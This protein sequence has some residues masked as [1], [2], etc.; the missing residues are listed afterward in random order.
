MHPRESFAET[1]PESPV[2]P[3]VGVQISLPVCLA[4]GMVLVD[5]A[6]SGSNTPTG[7]GLRVW[8]AMSD[9]ERDALRALRPALVHGLILTE[10]AL[11]H[12]SPDD[13]AHHDWVTLRTCLAALSPG[14][15]RELIAAGV[16]SGIDYYRRNMSSDPEAD[17][18]LTDVPASIATDSLVSDDC[19]FT[20]ALLADLATWGI[21]VDDRPAL[22]ARLTDPD[23]FRDDLL[24]AIS[25]I[26]THGMAQTWAAREADFAQFAREANARIASERFDDPVT[27]LTSLTG[28]RPPPSLEPEIAAARNLVLV[29]CP[30]LGTTMRTVVSENT[31]WELFE[32]IRRGAGVVR[33]AQDPA[34]LA[35]AVSRLHAITDPAAF[36]LVAELAVR[37]E[38]FAQELVDA[39]GMHQSTVSRHLTALEKGGIVTVRRD[40]K[41]KY[42]R[43]HDA[44]VR[45]SLATISRALGT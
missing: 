42:Y 1:F 5:Y 21:A 23:R 29:P 4:T 9:D 8:E 33:A 26:W 7:W 37:G 36:T 35:S 28:L 19:L 18:L 38:S 45:E 25:A 15:G 13:Q 14:T 12:L 10:F 20:I 31:T 17:D 27:A 30:E 3:R 11:Q 2:P 44:H 22:A 16:A 6:A 41:A 32:P 34:A 39:L 43:L 40:G 24:L